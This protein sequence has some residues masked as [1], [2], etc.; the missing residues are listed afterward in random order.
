MEEIPTH[1]MQRRE[2]LCKEE[3]DTNKNTTNGKHSIG[4]ELTKFWDDKPY[5]GTV[6][7]NTD[8]Y[9][10]IKYDDNDKEEMNHIEVTKYI[11]MHRGDGRMTREIGTRKRLQE[12]LGDWNISA[13][14]SERLWPFYYS[15]R[16]DTLYRSYRKDWHKQGEFTYN[17][18]T[19]NDNN[20]YDYTTSENIKE[21]P[22][23]AVPIE[24]MDT[25]EGW[26]MSGQLILMKTTK[27]GTRKETFQEYI[28][29][30][31]EYISQYYTQIEFLSTPIEI[32]K[33][34]KSTRKV[35]IATDGGAIPMKGSI[36]FVFADEDGNILLTFFGQPA[37]DNP[38]SFRSEI[39]AFLAAIRL[40]TLLNQYYDEILSCTEPARSK[41]Q[42]YTNSLS[43]IKKLKAYDKYP[44]APLTT[45]LDSEWDV[46]SALHRALKWF[47]TYPKITWVKSHQD[48]KVYDEQE[49]PLDAYLNSEAD[50]QATT[51]L[52]RLQEKPIVPMDPNT[53]VQ[54][55]IEGRTITRDF[56][57]TVREMIQLTPLRKVLLQ[58][59]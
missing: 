54:F 22:E 26:R 55:H 36:G 21:L 23:D 5:T 41:I 20:K 33:L 49:M 59:I 15:N 12:K 6:I 44:T 42:I 13:N 10:K 29:S 43:M 9:Y 1:N 46:L 58:S 18:H 45:V 25:E 57:R 11:R 17:C 53:I 27:T 39:C 32:Y 47:K 56:K 14:A 4:T 28:R 52:K 31:E 30:Q 50:K 48:E 19:R 35:L 7:S 37:G 38:L 8:T 3:K 24:A 34:F 40:V 16:K 2:R 51:G